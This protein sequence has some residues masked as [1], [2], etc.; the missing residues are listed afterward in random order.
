MNPGSDIIPL[1]RPVVL[2][3][4]LEYVAEAIRSGNPASGPFVERFEQALAARLRCPHVIAVSSGTAALH[5]ALLALGVGPG[6]KVL[7]PDLTFAAT[8]N[9]VIH[10]G[11]KPVFIDVEPD[12]WQMD[13]ARV[14]AILEGRGK[15]SLSTAGYILMPVDL[16]GYPCQ[17]FRLGSI[18]SV[19]GIPYLEDRAESLGTE[20]DG[21]PGISLACFSF[22]GNKVITA[23]AGGAVATQR[24]G[25][26]DFV[27]L[28]RNQ[29]AD[30]QDPG[31]HGQVGYNYRMPNMM[32]ALGLAQLEHLDEILAK[33]RDIASYYTRGL[34]GLGGVELPK[35]ASGVRPNWWLY[36]V[37]VREEALD[38]LL[39]AFEEAKIEAR[40]MFRPLSGLQAFENFP[41]GAL[42]QSHRI[43]RRALCLPSGPGLTSEDLDRVLDVLWR[44]LRGG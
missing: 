18:A 2:G 16:L 26:A 43:Y 15:A 6:H 31:G 44:E 29:G 37:L 21:D 38:R 17:R 4:E 3:K 24:S 7:V 22:N 27:R 20:V 34:E 5:L 28:L 30:P 9:A 11:A 39:K 13:P 42:I 10:C 41:G 12:Y 25:L 36:T 40:R 14:G 1:H 8:A 33:K 23:G 35:V 19:Y 32:A